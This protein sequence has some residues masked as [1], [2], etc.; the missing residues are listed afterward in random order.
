MSK[1]TVNTSLLREVVRTRFDGS[2]KLFSKA[3]GVS[4]SWL[5]KATSE[6]YDR[7]PK[8]LTIRAVA[9]A[10]KLSET[11]LFPLIESPPGK[12]TEEEAV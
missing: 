8:S 1:R 9:R 10:A 4:L 11:D 3:S 2:L 5:E 6:N 7:E 12:S